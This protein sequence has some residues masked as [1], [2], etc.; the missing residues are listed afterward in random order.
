[1]LLMMC[2]I[3]L[4]VVLDASRADAVASEAVSLAI[5]PSSLR[6]AVILLSVTNILHLLA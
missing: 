1:M 2:P 4:L 6:Q 3:V 5:L